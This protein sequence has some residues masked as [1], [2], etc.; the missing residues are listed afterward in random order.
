MRPRAALVVLLAAT[1]IPAAA[2]AAKRP[3]APPSASALEKQFSAALDSGRVAD[4]LVIADSLVVARGRLKGDSPVARAAASD[5][6]LVRFLAVGTPEA[7]A[8]A[9][10]MARRSLAE[11]EAAYGP[12]HLEVARSVSTVAS[13]LDY[14]GRWD[15]AVTLEQR[16]LDIRRAARGERDTLVAASERALGA[17]E[18]WLAQVAPAESL[19]AAALATYETAGPRFVGQVADAYLNLGEAV[20]VQGRY[21]EAAD[22]FRRGLAIAERSL[23]ASDPRRIS[24]VNSLAGLYKDQDRL[25]EAEPL[26][27]EALDLRR[28]AQPPDPEGTAIAELNLAEVYRLQGRYD[29]ARPLYEQSLAGAR[30]VLGADN[31][32]ALPFVNQVAVFYRESGALDRAE[33]L[34]REA[35]ASLEKTLGEDHPLT[36]QSLHDL[37]DLVAAEGRPAEAESLYRRALAIR[38]KT[39]GPRH[40]ETALTHLALARCIGSNPA[41]GNAAAAELA[42][43]RSV[44]STARAYPE[45]RIDVADLAS[46][47]A[48]RAGKPAQALAELEGVLDV[49][50]TLRAERGVSDEARAGYVARRLALY[51]RVFA[52]RL[53]SGNIAG[54]FEVHERARARVLLERI[55]GAGVDLRR[56]IPSPLRDTLDQRER[57]ARIALTRAQSALGEAQGRTDLKEAD[58]LELIAALEGTRDSL[59]AELDRAQDAIK[60]ASPV[61]REGLTSSG[62]PASLADVQRAVARPDAPLLVYHVGERGCAVFVVPSQ[63][64]VTV[65]HL[66]ADR[67]AAATLGIPAGPLKGSD[68]QAIL[69]GG[70]TSAGGRIRIGL[71]DWLSGRR[72]DPLSLASSEALS[73]D[74][75]AARLYALW[76]VLVPARAWVALHAARI[77]TIVVDGA[78]HRLPF[79]ALVT[80]AP[81]PDGGTTFWLDDG[82]APRY[83]SSATS[84]LSL[85]RRDATRAGPTPK[86]ARVAC[87]SV[88]DP[89]FANAA[90]ASADSPSGTRGSRTWAR[91]PATARESQAI[92]KAFAPDSVV[93][94]SGAG[95]TEAAVRAGLVGPQGPTFLHFATHAFVTERRSDV[96]AGL[97]LTPSRGADPTASDDGLLQIYEI[98]ELPLACRLA[99]LSACETERGPRVEGE[100]V[101]ALSR[102]FLA[103]GAKRVIASLWPVQDESTASL[104]AATFKPLAAARG[105]LPEGTEAVALRDAKRALRAQAPWHDPFYWAPFTLTGAP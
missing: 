48:E 37:A 54:A 79:D 85:V 18:F 63:G 26:L 104:V 102:A 100:G 13:L 42:K 72:Q 12:T 80:V 66:E 47:L 52:L 38:E 21:D 99:V 98:Y 9:E 8:A 4:A 5:S 35:L 69:E 25:I 62:R 58:R 14:Q 10:Q 53:Q 86:A 88:S 30:A 74:S 105:N 103:A 29:E 71:A 82:P 78:L 90:P 55:A 22:H 3:P 20:R 50:D 7:I 81:S 32:N 64:T 77:A 45:A 24:L 67:P 11:R 46:T 56:G 87:L 6:V 41:R 34:A 57:R 51:D 27:V 33:P 83:A 19:F 84:M 49:L 76:R 92:R 89:A 1:L 2:L 75:A 40:A 17:Y 94:L 31:P 28:A 91:L 73:P 101:F 97:V 43:A 16:S 95:A 68:L 36:A 96:L 15:E 39:L 23:P 70:R 59:A 44:L 93:V 61:W 60:G 65:E